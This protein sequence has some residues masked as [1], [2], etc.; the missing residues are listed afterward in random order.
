MVITNWELAGWSDT[1]LKDGKN[2]HVRSVYTPFSARLCLI[3]HSAI[4]SSIE[5]TC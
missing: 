1:A 5:G 4:K 2:T 3:S